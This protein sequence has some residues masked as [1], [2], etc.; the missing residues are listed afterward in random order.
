MNS[1][2]EVRDVN[3]GATQNMDL[4][5]GTT[6]MAGRDGRLVQMDLAQGDVHI[7]RAI[8]N[9][10]SGYRLQNGCADIAAPVVM[11]DNASNKYW[12]WDKNDAFQQAE[13]LVISPGAAPREIA[14]RLSTAAYTTV[15]Y[16][17]GAFIPTELQANADSPLNLYL[18]H[19]TRI[20]N[21]LTLAR[22][23][24]VATMMRLP[25][26]YTGFSTTASSTSKWNSGTASD[27]IADLYTRAEAALQPITD[28]IMSEQ[29]WHDFVR[30]AAVQK[31]TG[32]KSMVPGLTG[33]T[34]Q[35]GNVAGLSEFAAILGLPRIHVA[36]MKYL[37]STG[38]YSYVW[39][40]DAVLVHKPAT[41]FPIDG[42]D[43]ATAYTFRWK[44]GDVGD[45]QVDNGFIVRSFFVPNRGPRGGTQ[46][47]VTHNDAEQFIASNVSGLIIGA[48]Q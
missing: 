16:A 24:R 28:V 40:G 12:Q 13:S 17:L 23:I 27:P 8:A 33:M 14:P 21:A 20:M 45:A 22:E 4:F 36:A 15:G 31:Y 39:G 7:D 37:D 25:G 30:N 9:Y 44:G 19:M 18:A 32:F 46:I 48:H 42:Q 5:T 3:G 11:V 1:M 47:V 34:T 41:E 26:N 43:I 10:A 29:L 38:N 2:I 35:N 6:Q